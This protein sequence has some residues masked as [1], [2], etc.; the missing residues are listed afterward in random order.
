[1]LLVALGGAI[2]S[3]L[4]YAAALLALRW[5]GT[6][7]PWGTLAV[8]LVGSFVIG[9]VHEMGADVLA[10]MGKCTI[11]L[12]DEFA[13]IAPAVRSCRLT[14]TLRSGRTVVAEYRRSLEDD[15]SDSG[16]TQ[17][18]AKLGAL[19]KGRLGGAAREGL[20]ERISALE[21]Q[22]D[23]RELIALTKLGTA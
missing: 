11:E 15:T 18:V 13:N 8:N 20:V 21:D 14:A 19:T 7:F 4:R 23:L 12:P 16:W 3:V 17:A 10:L 9:L 6:E 1:M 22:R 5:L 2:G